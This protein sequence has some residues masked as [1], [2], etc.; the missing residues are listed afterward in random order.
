MTTKPIIER[1]KMLLVDKITNR[2]VLCELPGKSKRTIIREIQRG[3]VLHSYDNPPFERPEY[4]AWHAE[5]DA[6]SHDGAKGSDYKIGSDRRLLDEISRLMGA[7]HPYSP[8]AVIQHFKL[9]GWPTDTR[10]CEK[11]LYKYIYEG[12]IPNVDKGNLL[13]KGIRHKPGDI[14]RRHSNAENAAGTID[15]RPKSANDRSEFGH[16]EGDTVVGG[17]GKGTGC[18]LTLTERKQRLE[19]I[20]PISDRR[21]AP[22]VRELDTIERALGSGLFRRVFQ[23]ITFDNGCEFSDCLGMERQEN[24]PLLRL[25]IL[26]LS[27]LSAILVFDASER[28]ERSMIIRWL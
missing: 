15:R 17:S 4:N 28:E 21:A 8:Y 26:M 10:I 27:I 24:H 18:V 22:V 12:L 25:S 23:S 13:L 19:I 6:R 9:T 20:R 2:R 5:L 11:T 3:T 1:E 14:I 16:W 7:S